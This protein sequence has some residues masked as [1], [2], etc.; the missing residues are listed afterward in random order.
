MSGQDVSHSTGAGVAT[1][2]CSCTPAQGVRARQ[3]HQL[4]VVEAHAGEHVADVGCALGG[5]RQPVQAPQPGMTEGKGLCQLLGLPHMPGHATLHSSIHAACSGA[6][7][8]I[9]RVDTLAVAR[10]PASP[11]QAANQVPKGAWDAHPAACYA[12]MFPAACLEEADP[13]ATLTSKGK[14]LLVQGRPGHRRL[15][16]C[17]YSPVPNQ[18]GSVK[19][20]PAIGR[21]LG[22]IDLVT[23][24]RPPM[25]VRACAQQRLR[26]EHVLGVA[27]C[28]RPRSF[29]M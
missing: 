24:A 14:L 9:C 12:I 26:L 13:E 8:C 18:V 23:A 28:W 2:A 29:G 20:P 11:V 21:A 15:V 4:L 16:A 5:I 1:A 6:S 25:Y 27:Q 10:M 22:A 7:S 3:G 19:T 17:S